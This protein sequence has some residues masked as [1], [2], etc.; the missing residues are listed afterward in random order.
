M[1]HDLEK[2]V[3]SRL[4]GLA[5]NCMH[6]PWFIVNFSNIL[7]LIRTFNTKLGNPVNLECMRRP[8]FIV[9]LM[10]AYTQ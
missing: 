6:H 2:Q 3:P 9:Q 4:L 8:T 5:E 1:K 10:T 7:T